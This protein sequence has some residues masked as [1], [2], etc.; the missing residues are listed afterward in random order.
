VPYGIDLKKF[1]YNEE[2]PPKEKRIGYVGRVENWK[3]LDQIQKAA[4]ELKEKIL[5]MGA[6][7]K[8]VY[9][10][11]FPKDNI[12][13]DLECSDEKLLENYKKMSV[14]VN[15]SRPGRESGPLPVLEAMA[16]GVPVVTTRTGMAQDI[17]RD[18]YNCKITDDEATNL[19]KNI[20]VILDDPKYAE[21]LR[22]SGWNTIKNYS[23]EKFARRYARIY[24]EVIFEGINSVSVIIP[25]YNRADNL[26]KLLKHY[27]KQTYPNF[28]I[29]VCDDN[30]TDNT[31]EIVMKA[32]KELNLTIKY[33]NTKTD[34]YGLA[35]ARNLGI[36][37]AEGRWLMFCDDRLAPEPKAISNFLLFA[38]N[39]PGKIWFHGNKG[40]DKTSFV[41]NFSF[42]QKTLVTTMGMFNERL[43]KY[44]GMTQDIKTRW[45]KIWSGDD[46]GGGQFKYYHEA[47]FEE[48]VS[49]KAK[50][51]RVDIVDSKYLLYKTLQEPN[52]QTFFKN[53]RTSVKDI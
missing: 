17:G 6:K 35:K 9:W 42:V 34:G 19:S 33:V 36:I 38:T 24:R 10:D 40:G 3:R 37:E 43:T 18:G 30:S 52:E 8:P 7:G 1:K 23:D 21:K 41:E 14:F 53:K 2:Y 32:R 46:D 28:E 20:K 13:F 5:A 22:Q 50:N 16:M 47:R 45:E 51:K 29:V 26:E 4:V 48:W 44:G 39:R 15:N 25:T 12:E 49:S 27:E 31:K 11:S